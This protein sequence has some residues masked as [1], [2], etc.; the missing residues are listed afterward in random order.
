MHIIITIIYIYN[1]FTTRGEYALYFVTNVR[2]STRLR[3]CAVRTQR[4]A[5]LLSSMHTALVCACTHTTLV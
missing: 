1:I 5:M 4:K 3:G 2:A